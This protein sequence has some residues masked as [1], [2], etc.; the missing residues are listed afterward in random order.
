[1][2]ATLVLVI[3][4]T[5]THGHL[6]AARTRGCDDDQRTLGLDIIVLAKALVRSDEGNVVGIA[7]YKI[8][9]I[10]LD[11]FALQA[12][13]EGGG[14]GLSVIMGYDNRAHHEPTV[15]KLATKTQHILVIGYA[16]VGTFLV[17]LYVGGTDDNNDLYAVAQLLEH[18][19]LAVGHESRQHAAGMMIIEKFA[20]KFEVKFSVKL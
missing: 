1:M 3:Q 18:A 15:L 19:Q 13:T 20:S 2:H 9:I 6:A 11:A 10:G 16:E 8:M 4:L 12:L 5:E 17:L 7:L 14:G